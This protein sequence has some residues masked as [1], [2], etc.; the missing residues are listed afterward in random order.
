MKNYVLSKNKSIEPKERT[1]IQ[2][3]SEQDRIKKSYDKKAG[4]YTAK[5]EDSL[6]KAKVND[7]PYLEI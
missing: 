3:C 7:T 1:L 2:K 4:K 6:Y 5:P